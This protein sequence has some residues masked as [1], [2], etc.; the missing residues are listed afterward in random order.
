MQGLQFLNE[1]K[2]ALYAFKKLIFGMMIKTFICVKL[3]E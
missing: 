3:M 2:L 1:Y